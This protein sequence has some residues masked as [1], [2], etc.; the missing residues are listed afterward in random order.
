MTAKAED[1]VYRLDGLKW[2]LVI[3]MMV[4]AIWAYYQYEEQVGDLYR[5]LALVGVALVAVLIAGQTAKGA[6]AWN[7]RRDVLIEFRK[8]VW[9]TRA[10]TNRT[11]LIILALVAVAGVIL[12][13][14]DSLFGWLVSLVL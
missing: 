5:V 7:L 9:P 14:V 2:L 4:A 12:W 8:I 6:A 1:K 10:E 11:T 13:G 3:G